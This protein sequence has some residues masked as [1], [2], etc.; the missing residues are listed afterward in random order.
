MTGKDGHEATTV[1][2]SATEVHVRAPHKAAPLHALRR[3]LAGVS[4]RLGDQCEVDES[5]VP[6]DSEEQQ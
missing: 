4:Q 1:R 5:G 6:N 2:S 3:P